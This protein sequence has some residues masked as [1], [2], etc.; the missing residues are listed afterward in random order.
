ML[1]S[2]NVTERTPED[3]EKR[4]AYYREWYAKRK[5]EAKR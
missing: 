4:N 5:K 2:G 1:G 3:R